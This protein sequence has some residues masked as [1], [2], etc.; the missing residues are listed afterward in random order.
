[1]FPDPFKVN[2]YT[3]DENGHNRTFFFLSFFMSHNYHFVLALS[4]TLAMLNISRVETPCT[5]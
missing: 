3:V 4:L 5:H 1:M 2:M